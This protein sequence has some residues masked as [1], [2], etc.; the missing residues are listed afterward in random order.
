MNTQLL[1][2]LRL[3]E[4]ICLGMCLAISL[5]SRIGGC[6][7]VND[8]NQTEWL[9]SQTH[10]IQTSCA[11]DILIFIHPTGCVSIFNFFCLLHPK[12]SVSYKQLSNF[13]DTYPTR[14]SNGIM[15]GYIHR[16]ATCNGQW[17]RFAS[18]TREALEH[19]LVMSLYHRSRGICLLDTFIK[20]IQE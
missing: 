2:I 18:F 17:L 19:G 20:V 8:R 16:K 15:Q 4:N 9:H 5:G 7:F 13:S 3:A 11:D 6:I 14:H 12:C 1:K 10:F